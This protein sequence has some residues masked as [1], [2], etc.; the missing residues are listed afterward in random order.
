M[1]VVHHS[2]HLT[3]NPPVEIYDGVPAP[4]AELPARAVS[5]V[6]ALRHDA[7]YSFVTPKTFPREHIQALHA[8]CYIDFLEA[9]SKLLAP[10]ETLHPSYFITD[11]YAPMVRGTF[12]AAV[13]AVDIA[14]TAAEI[15]IEGQP[16][17][18][19]L[20]RPPGHHATRDTMGGYCYFNNAAIAAERMS[21]LGKVAVLDIDFHH[22]NGTQRLFYERCDVLYVSIHADPE[23]HYPYSTG[24][25]DETGVGAGLGFTSNFPLPS[26]TSDAAYEAALLT[27]LDAVAAFDPAMVV[28]SAGFDT[29]ERDPIGDFALTIPFYET[30]GTHIKTLGR[31]TLVLQE[32]GYCVEELGPI[33]STFLHPLHSAL[34][35]A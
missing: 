19:A 23:S 9:R 12:D 33:V 25:R 15:V 6:E 18:Y 26:A 7:R 27:A 21:T 3:H 34:P 24:Y 2:Q 11:T 16:V 28:I 35:A 17:A 8:D 30:V 32:G 5:I 1:H 10:G 20:C 14:L 22:G 31:P 13:V 4:H 29:Y